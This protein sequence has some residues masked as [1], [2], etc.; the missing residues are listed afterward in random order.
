MRENEVDSKAL[1]E[2]EVGSYDEANSDVVVKFFVVAVSFF[3]GGVKSPRRGSL[4]A[5]RRMT[6]IAR[7]STAT[8][9]CVER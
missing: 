1:S 3:A 5:M 7:T 9:C 4:R 2:S 8:S 6:L